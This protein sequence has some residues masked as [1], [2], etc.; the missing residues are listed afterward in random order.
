MTEE[1]KRGRPPKQAEPEQLN[2][3]FGQ[4]HLTKPHDQYVVKCGA[5]VVYAS[6]SEADARRYIEL[7]NK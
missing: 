7:L 1:K 6:L 3:A 5:S 4:Y 2:E